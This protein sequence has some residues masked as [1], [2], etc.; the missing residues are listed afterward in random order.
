MRIAVNASLL[1]R[2]PTGLGVYI[3]HMIVSLLTLF[4]DDERV[5]LYTSVP[6]RFV[7]VTRGA[8][9][10]RISSRL[11]PRYGTP[12]ALA[13]LLWTQ[14]LF[15]LAAKGHELIYNPTHHGVLWRRRAQIITIHD[16]LPLHFPAQYRLQHIYFRTVLPRLLKTA[17][18]VVVDSEHTRGDVQR[19]Y[20]TPLEKI[21]VVH[22]GAD[23]VRPHSGTDVD[24]EEK[25]GLRHYMLAVG[26]SYPHKNVMRALE[27]F[28]VAKRSVPDLQFALIGGPSDYLASVKR[29]V[30]E[31][32]LTGVTFLGYVEHRDLPQL[33]S[34]AAAFI[35]P[36]L[37]EGF[38]LPPLEAM[39]HRCPAIVSRA[40]SLPEVCGEAAYYV[41]PLSVE[42]MAQAIIAV[43]RSRA[44]QDELRFKGAQRASLYTWDN[45]AKQV[46]SVFQHVVHGSPAPRQV[47]VA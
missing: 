13:R 10:R 4:G 46:Y 1:D 22:C 8:R 27:A 39:V 19:A 14:T 3:E 5:T 6:E 12:A 20:G 35:Y 30:G 40:S 21:W 44:L 11:E 33:Y 28:A 26:A 45:A 41:D 47:V 29:Y 16:L 7:S 23:H 38:G 32:G 2:R 43:V 34:S 15:P 9:I 17:T 24:L 42:D 25:Y 31:I 18:A 36:S 37:Y